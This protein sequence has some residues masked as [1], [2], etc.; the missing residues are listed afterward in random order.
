MSQG[1]LSE[2]SEDL[3]SEL[4]NNIPEDEEDEDVSVQSQSSQG[5]G[6]PRIPE[7]WTRVVSLKHDNLEN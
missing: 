2:G 4:D 6:R 7:K 5:R 1:R 3:I